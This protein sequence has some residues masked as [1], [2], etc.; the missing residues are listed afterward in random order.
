MEG[1]R[2]FSHTLTEA[3]LMNG[4]FTLSTW[5]EDVASPDVTRDFWPYRTP[6]HNYEAI[7]ENLP[8]LKV[9]ISFA[10]KDH[11]QA[12]LDKPHIRQA[13]DGFRKRAGLWTRLNCDLS[14][15]QAEI[16]ASASL[17]GGFPDNDANSEPTDWY[18]QAESWGFAEKLAGELT[19][20]TIPLAGIAEMADRVQANN[21]EKNLPSV[22]RIP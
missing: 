6:I 17:A 18:S 3:L 8:D 5:P 10:S 16:D 9:L 11:V 13:Y 20:R 7:G 12:A 1:K 15:V 4:V 21:W 19:A 22:I 14:Y 2:Y